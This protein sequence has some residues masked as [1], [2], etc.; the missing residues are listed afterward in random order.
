MSITR[1]V[2]NTAVIPIIDSNWAD[3]YNYIVGIPPVP[4][5]TSENNVPMKLAI[6]QNNSTNCSL[7]Q[8]RQNNTKQNYLSCIEDKTRNIKFAKNFL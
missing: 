1:D 5:A 4:Q 6:I 2:F 8:L 3:V 7:P